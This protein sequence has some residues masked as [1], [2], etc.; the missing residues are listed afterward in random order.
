MKLSLRLSLT[1]DKFCG[2]VIIIIIIDR[3]RQL[4]IEQFEL[5]NSELEHLTIIN[6][7]L[8]FWMCVAAQ[9][10]RSV[11][12]FG[13]LTGPFLSEIGEVPRRYPKSSLLPTSNFM[14]FKLF[15]AA[16]GW[17]TTRPAKCS[18]IS[19]FSKVDVITPFN[20]QRSALLQQCKAAMTEKL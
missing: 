1:I 10:G 14:P 5:L 15:P 16:I 2:Q 13:I 6:S 19:L 8:K 17:A 12:V 7:F 18:L 4:M 20:N 11:A 9:C 3:R